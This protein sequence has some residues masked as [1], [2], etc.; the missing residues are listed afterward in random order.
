VVGR[1]KNMKAKLAEQTA[2]RS[3]TFTLHRSPN[4]SRA[5]QNQQS[6]TRSLASGLENKQ[7]IA[8]DG[9]IQY[10]WADEQ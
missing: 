10:R 4:Q 1:E 8:K 2:A 9:I 3:G 5:I 7:G 6:S